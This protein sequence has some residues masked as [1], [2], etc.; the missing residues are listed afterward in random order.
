MKKLDKNSLDL[1]KENI[2]KLI[3]KDDSFTTS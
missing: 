2:E 1:V 3:L